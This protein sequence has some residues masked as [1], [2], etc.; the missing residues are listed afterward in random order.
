MKKKIIGMILVFAFMLS[1]VSMTATA[2]AQTEITEVSIS[3]LDFPVVGQTLDADYNIP[4]SGIYYQKDI[5]KPE[6][7]WYIYDNNTEKFVQVDADANVQ[8][9][10]LYKAELYLNRIN[11]DYIFDQQKNDVT[12][13]ATTSMEGKI[14]SAKSV[15]EK[16]DTLRVEVT[17]IGNMVYDAANNWVGLN[18]NRDVPYWPVAGETPWTDGVITNANTNE[19]PNQKD[20]TIATEWFKKEDKNKALADDYQFE[21]GKE[22]ILRVTLNADRSAIFGTESLEPPVFITNDN[23]IG[24]TVSAT[25]EK[26]VIEFSFTVFGGVFAASI[27]GIKPPVAGESVQKDGFTISALGATVALAGWEYNNGSDELFHEFTGNVFENDVTYRLKLKIAPK[28]GFSLNLQKDD[29]DLNCGIIADFSRNQEE[30]YLIIGI[31]F[32]TDKEVIDTI[33]AYITIPQD[34]QF[35]SY[36]ATVP[37]NAGYIVGFKTNDYTVNGVYWHSVTHEEPMAPN[38]T[39][40]EKGKEYSVTIQ[41]IPTDVSFPEKV[42]D[43]FAT[44]NGQKAECIYDEN[45]ILN[46]SYT[47]VAIEAIT[48]T[49]GDVNNDGKINAKDALVVLKIAVNKY[50]PDNSELFAADVN[51]DN[52][53]NAKDAL[54]ILKYAVN[55]PSCLG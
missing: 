17:F 21:A 10:E 28:D 39:P 16:A 45:G 7:V 3:G 5:N 30:G 48:N 12:V 50:T 32:K 35:P 55:K 6:V 27:E 19:N 36:N 43:I 8:Y 34:A 51:K 25:A 52:S 14:V 37:V 42:E 13:N 41:I 24:E 53:I 26:M 9:G 31:D 1:M 15:V 29:I 4:S 44:I 38:I 11:S 54:E 18:V 2:N 22:Y 33:A 47:Y 23:V 49:L 20:F 46:I 40:F